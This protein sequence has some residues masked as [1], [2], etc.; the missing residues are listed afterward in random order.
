M[1]FF[2]P[3]DIISSVYKVYEVVNVHYQE[4]SDQIEHFFIGLS[5]LITAFTGPDVG[6]SAERED[7][8]GQSPRPVPTRW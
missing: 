5:G 1:Y 2:L 6:P 4:L 8:G 7:A 3:L